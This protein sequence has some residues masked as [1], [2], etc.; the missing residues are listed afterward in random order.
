M[1]QRR[2]KAQTEVV[3]KARSESPSSIESIIRATRDLISGSYGVESHVEQISGKVASTEGISEE[4]KI[5]ANQ[6]VEK[7]KQTI[8]EAEQAIKDLLTFP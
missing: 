3:K 1:Q 8:T 5:S 2:L 7:A 4:T 6:A